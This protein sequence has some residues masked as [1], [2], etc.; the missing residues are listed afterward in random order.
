MNRYAMNWIP[1]LMHNP[2][3]MKLKEQRE[4]LSEISLK[5]CLISVYHNEILR[6]A[7]YGEPSR[8]GPL[9]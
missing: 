2:Q 8:L 6:V 7:E 5:Q 1:V 9:F 3:K 4:C